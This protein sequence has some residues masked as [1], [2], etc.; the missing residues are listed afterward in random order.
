M[1]Y[2][3]YQIVIN[4][5]YKSLDEFKEAFSKSSLDDLFLFN[6]KE[7]SFDKRFIYIFK[8]LT[9]TISL[10]MSA[11]ISGG[12]INIRTF[13][14]TNNKLSLLNKRN[15]CI[16][17][18]KSLEHLIDIMKV[19]FEYDY[20]ECKEQVLED[21]EETEEDDGNGYELAI[22]NPYK[23]LEELEKDMAEIVNEDDV[24][25]P[26]IVFTRYINEEETLILSLEVADDKLFIN[27][28][29]YFD[30]SY[31]L[32]IAYR[33]NLS[34]YETLGDL[35]TEMEE[36]FEYNYA[37]ALHDRKMNCDEDF[38]YEDEEVE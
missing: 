11:E 37:I 21:D 23:N 2:D 20:L 26:L 1:F 29:I 15:E 31:T 24:I 13:N 4:N 38:Y 14:L 30:N 35:L 17:D 36:H 27:T 9:E 22:D 19:H 6:F 25:V 12:D 3:K 32:W 16:N 34:D 7:G 33:I 28:Y 18:Y 8:P 10:A 5:P